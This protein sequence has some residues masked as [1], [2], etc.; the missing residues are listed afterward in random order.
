MDKHYRTTHK[1]E[2]E[3]KEKLESWIKEINKKA[4]L[5]KKLKKTFEKSKNHTKTPSKHTRVQ[6]LAGLHAKY[7]LPNIG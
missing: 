5:D 7:C 1:D 2:K 3:I 4:I 6:I